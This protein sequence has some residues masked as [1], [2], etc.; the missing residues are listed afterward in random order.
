MAE[1]RKA[2]LSIFTLADWNNPAIAANKVIGD[3]GIYEVAVGVDPADNNRVDIRVSDGIS[4]KIWSQLKSS[5]LTL[6]NLKPLLDGTYQRELV[7]GN[8]I[9]I[10]ETDPARPRISVILSAVAHNALGGR[11]TADAHPINAVTGLS[12][13]LETLQDNID[14][15]ITRASGVENTIAT[16]LSNEVTRATAA[17][18]TNAGAITAETTRATAVEQANASAITAETTRATIAENALDTA[19]LEKTAVNTNLTADIAYN[20]NAT[21]VQTTISYLNPATGAASSANKDIPLA[22]GEAAGLMSKEDVV[23]IQQNTADINTLMGGIGIN[24]VITLSTTTPSQA[25]LQSAYETASGKTGAAPDGTNLFDETNNKNYRWYSTANNWKNVDTQV[26]VATNSAPGIVQ[27]SSDTGKVYVETNGAMS[28]NGWDALNNSVNS[29]AADNVVV[30]LTGNE[31]ISDTKTFSTSPVV[32]SKIAAATNS[33]TAIATE[34]Q[35]YSHTSNNSNPHSVTKAQVGLGNADNTA[36][37]DK[38]VSTAMQTALDNKQGKITAT[39]TTNVLTAPVEAG[40][41]PGTVQIGVANGIA[42]L[43]ANGKVPLANLPE[44]QIKTALD[45]PIVTGIEYH[46]GNI[47]SLTVTYPSDNFICW[48]SFTASADF[49]PS[50]PTTKWANGEAPS[51][52]SG[53]AYRMTFNRIDA[54]TVIGTCVAFG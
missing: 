32:P 27:G 22:T 36:D 48:V 38:P 13:E 15:E 4:G 29:K 8:G 54:S 52:E 44:A 37:A 16:N 51:I 7:A 10:D 1:V 12:A 53:N 5:A 11:D 21:N 26:P 35:V 39:G 41:Q 3:N 28:V 2:R 25:D 23:Q 30:H 19:K 40:G 14:T 20:Q 43:D 47:S 33:G 50:I 46:L 49:T 9:N 18:Q 31:T 6:N 42:P 17:E 34:A 24:F 45:T